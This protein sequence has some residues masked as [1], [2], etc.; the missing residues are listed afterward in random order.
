MDNTQ[1]KPALLQERLRLLF[2][3][4]FTAMDIAEPLLAF[5]GETKAVDVQKALRQRNLEI[6]GVQ[7]DGIMVGY[8]NLEQ[9]SSGCCRDHRIDFSP[10]QVLSHSASYQEVIEAL[11]RKGLCFVTFLGTVS[12]IVQKADIK[13]PSVRMWLFGLIT[14]A[15]MI[16]TS[17]VEE[18]FPSG[19]WQEKLPEARLRK[20]RELQKERRRIGQELSLLECL[21]FADKASILIR[22]SPFRADAGFQSKTEAK[23]A[24]SK[25]ESL[26]N[27]LAHTHDIVV[28]DWDT[29]VEMSRRLDR[30]L[31][32]L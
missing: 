23:K 32:R 11:D 30:M 24:I 27:S 5:A 9:L 21:Y 2:K 25:L 20:A 7:E 6:G 18:H 15:E 4:G 16:I 1:F 17:Q 22:E 8:V 31:S 26:R 29:I 19:Q 28:H 3:T 13:K 14:I 12:G 10:E